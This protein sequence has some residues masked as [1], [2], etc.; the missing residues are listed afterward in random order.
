MR[1][2][3]LDDEPDICMLV[4]A[5]V[6]RWGHECESAHTVARGRDLCETFRPDVLLLDVAMPEQ[7]GPTFLTDIRA[8]GLAPRHVVFLSAIPAE[9]LRALADEHGVGAISKPFTAEALE[10]ACGPILGGCR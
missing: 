9:E 5:N 2:L 6:R 8:A 4:R 7:D 3:I 10:T 1:V